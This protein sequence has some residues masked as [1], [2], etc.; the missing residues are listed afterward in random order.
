MSASKDFLNSGNLSS[1]QQGWGI[2]PA[3]ENQPTAVRSTGDTLTLK[4]L[5]SK[6]QLC[7]SEKVI[8]KYSKNS[9]R[10]F[11]FWSQNY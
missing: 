10:Q 7:L 6:G 9:I 8:L 5:A 11:L 1:V 2:S 4:S 3:A